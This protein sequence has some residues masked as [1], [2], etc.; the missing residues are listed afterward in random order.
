MRRL[1]LF[2][3]LEG[4]GSFITACATFS[5]FDFKVLGSIPCLHGFRHGVQQAFSFSLGLN[6]RLALQRDVFHF[7]F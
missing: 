5:S 4:I 2:V 1:L 6:A 3:Y 7:V